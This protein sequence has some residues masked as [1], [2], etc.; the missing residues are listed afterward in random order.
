MAY[1]MKI[2]NFLLLRLMCSAIQKFDCENAYTN[3][4]IF[5]ILSK[6]FHSVCRYFAT[7]KLQS[8]MENSEL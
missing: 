3:K 4:E 5:K 1:T 8:I 2:D 6:N 7:K